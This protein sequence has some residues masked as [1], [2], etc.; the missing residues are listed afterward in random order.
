MANTTLLLE[1]DG[2]EV[3]ADDLEHIDEIQ[4]EE[5]TW[6]A[7][8]A[9]LSAKLEPTDDGEWVSPLDALVVPRTGLVIQVTRDDVVYRFDGYS[10]EAT[11]EIDA[12][13]ASKL[14]VKA[15]DR[16]LDLDAEE[17]VVGW[18]G[19]GD[20]A[21]A[22]A[23]FGA[24]GMT[25]Q[26]TD[27]PAGPDPDVHVAFQRGTDWAFLRALAGKW[28]YVTYLDAAE[29]GVTGYF[30]PL[31]PTA[32]PQA[33]L[34]L[35]FGGDAYK[36]S[37]EGQLTAGHRVKVSRVPPLSDTPAT[38]DSA[39]D[40][41]AQGAAPL[42]GAVT[43]LLAPTDVDGEV[44]PQRAADG[45]AGRS[46]Y[47]VTLTAEID[48]DRLGV[49]FRARRPVLV[50][51]LG[52]TLSGQYLVEKVRHQVTLAAHRQRLTLRRNALGVTGGEPFGAL[53][54]GLF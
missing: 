19:A 20:S 34:A 46:A 37:V 28:G 9:T 49:L 17:K 23:I 6:E 44:D 39:G 45:L 15:I 43:V 11:W 4:V 35:G 38:G 25:A 16:S 27:T 31:D 14:T 18:P 33:E 8:A 32:D 24:H 12:E 40:A 53:G 10:T 48:T 52:S 42:G 41:D 36:V 2:T 29:D 3:A 1:I 50:K 47:G 54:G 26:V 51:G 21:I 13:G 5:A 7:D 30:G 22:S